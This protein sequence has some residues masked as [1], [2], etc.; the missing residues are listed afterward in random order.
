MK[1]LNNLNHGQFRL[2]LNVGAQYFYLTIN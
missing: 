1:T 2:K